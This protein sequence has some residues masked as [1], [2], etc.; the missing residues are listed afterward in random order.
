MNFLEAVSQVFPEGAKV[1][2]GTPVQSTIGVEVHGLQR[3]FVPRNCEI[4]ASGQF[5]YFANQES[6]NAYLVKIQDYVLL[7]R[8]LPCRRTPNRLYAEVSLR[9]PTHDH[10]RTV[11]LF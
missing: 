10:A 11:G 2:D 4:I 8:I 1:T 3:D 6:R 7:V 9:R 5:Q